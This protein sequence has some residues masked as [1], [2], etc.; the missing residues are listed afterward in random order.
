MY[1]DDDDPDFVLSKADAKKIEVAQA[2]EL[3]DP[4]PVPSARPAVGVL[5]D[6]QLSGKQQTPLSRASS[7]KAHEHT[8]FA[9]NASD[10]VQA[11]K[12]KSHSAAV[13]K[14][15]NAGSTDGAQATAGTSGGQ[16]STAKP[17]Q[18]DS[19]PAC[20][21]GSAAKHGSS[22]KHSDLSSESKSEAGLHG[23]ASSPA[24][25]GMAVKVSQASCQLCTCMTS[26]NQ[27]KL[28]LP[29]FVTM[30]A[31]VPSSAL[32]QYPNY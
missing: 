31:S 29:I 30:S 26:P 19:M 2:A 21:A 11:S 32:L 24:A 15:P 3:Q 23:T 18:Q 10:P 27:S 9:A 8:T 14:E 5:E 22:A 7:K 4:D 20:P 16:A 17:Q 13:V 6:K 28:L 1:G 12:A 25:K